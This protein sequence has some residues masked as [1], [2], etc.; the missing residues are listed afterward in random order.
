MVMGDAKRNVLENIQ[1]KIDNISNSKMSKGVIV[2]LFWKGRVTMFGIKFV[3]FVSS[4]LTRVRDESIRTA[5]PT[6]V[7]LWMLID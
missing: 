1:I 3:L 2:S 5:Q 4:S 6:C 7:R